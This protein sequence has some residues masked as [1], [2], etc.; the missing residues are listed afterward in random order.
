MKLIRV[1]PRKT[2]ATPMDE[3]V[4][5][6][7]PTLFDEADEV[8][9]SVT[10]T[11]D[12]GKADE[13]Y[14]QWRHVAPTKIGGV[15]L[16]D[17]GEEFISGKYLKKG[18][19]ITSRGCP[20]RCWFCSVWKREGNE[21]RELTIVDGYNILDD[22]LLACSNEHIKRVFEM[23][24]NQKEKSLFTGGLEAARLK[25]WHVDEL[26]KLKPKRLYFAYDTKDDYEPLKI[27]GKMLLDAGFTKA[28]HTL[29]CYV[30]IGYPKDEFG[31]A[32]K[33]LAETLDAGFTPMAMLW[34]NQGGKTDIQWRRFQRRWVRPSIIYA[35]EQKAL[36]NWLL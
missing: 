8:H 34:R 32:E 1:F 7:A 26:I 16:G 3:A 23:L 36:E 12:L 4:S 14:K 6:T 19:V 20:N 33:R 9:I 21:V 5:F 28:S 2:N 15:A 22:N 30:L 17:K 10:F 18:Y 29:R 35:R 25:K 11:Y 24:K 31:D 27:A 13:L